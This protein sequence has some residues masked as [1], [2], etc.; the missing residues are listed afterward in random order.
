[1][2]KSIIKNIKRSLFL[3]LLTASITIGHSTEASAED[4]F[5]DY[6]KPITI[7]ETR[8][9]AVTTGRFN[10]IKR[11]AGEVAKDRAAPK[12]T[13]VEKT[14]TIK[15]SKKSKK[16]TK[17]APDKPAYLEGVKAED[18]R[19][20]DVS[21]TLKVDDSQVD[22]YEIGI[23]SVEITATD[24][25]GNVASKQAKVIITDGI[26]PSIKIEGKSLNAKKKGDKSNYAEKI[27]IK[28]NE[29]SRD[30]LKI[31]ID[32]SKVDYSKYG[33]Y[34]VAVTATDTA[35]NK[36]KK[37]FTVN[38]KDKKGPTI[39][40]DKKSFTTTIGVP[41]DFT[42]NVTV[43]D[44][45]GV[46]EYS[47]DDSNIDYWTAGKYKLHITAT[48]KAGNASKKDVK[49]TVKDPE[50]E[51]QAAW[52]AEQAAMQTRAVATAE[53]TVCITNTGNKYHSAGCRYTKKSC[54]EVSLSDALARGLEPCSV[55]NP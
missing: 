8:P 28:D 55:C 10:E 1:M 12:I 18:Y 15:Q 51:A 52:E 16:D 23:Y 45:S 26:A 37:E 6:K 36:N 48:D 29:D 44:G 38:I 50:A 25:T 7:T 39:T 35:G 5:A 43:K 47:I 13:G 49:V 14:Y 4:S 11:I 20:G 19:D 2:K 27:I 17:N 41:L 24:Q 21:T 46:K 31:K 54:I 9:D 34:K 33:T 40:V 53:R 3:F 22:Y 42:P 30:D 32:D